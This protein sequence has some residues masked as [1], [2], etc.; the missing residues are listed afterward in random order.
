MEYLLKLN[1]NI[2]HICGFAPVLLENKYFWLST[3]NTNKTA[4]P[5]FKEKLDIN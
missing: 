5:N 1:A 4:T 3:R 2:L